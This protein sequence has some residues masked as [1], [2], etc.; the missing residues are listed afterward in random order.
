[1]FSSS[2]CSRR[3]TKA[4][5]GAIG[6]R[7]GYTEFEPLGA[8]VPRNPVIT[9]DISKLASVRPAEIR[10]RP[11]A[12]R[13]RD[14]D[15]LA[16][17]WNVTDEIIV[18]TLRQRARDRFDAV[19]VLVLRHEVVS[20]RIITALDRH[21]QDETLD[22]NLT[23]WLL[24]IEAFWE[25]LSAHGFGE[26]VAV[27]STAANTRGASS[28]RIY[29]ALNGGLHAMAKFLPRAGAADGIYVDVVA[30]G[31]Y[32]PRCSAPTPARARRPS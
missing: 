3:I 14:R 29:D 1:M 11:A 16:A 24:I 19:E 17:S 27:G 23:S 26:M 2:L 9:C 21:S 8:D 10:F 22:A 5:F 30:S 28:G 32:K 20:R 15:C 25:D 7:R 13:E 31:R 4:V 12:S 6:G 18:A